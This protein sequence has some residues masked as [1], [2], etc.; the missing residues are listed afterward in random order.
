MASASAQF[1]DANRTRLLDE[2]LEFLRIPSVST[3]P[4]HQNDVR[5][6]AAFVAN[7]LQKAGMENVEVIETE[8]HPLVYADWMHAAGKPTVLC[9]GHYDVQPPDPVELWHSPPL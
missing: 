4:E 6:A 1:V 3:L 2:L 7:G 9:Y 5:S 8:G